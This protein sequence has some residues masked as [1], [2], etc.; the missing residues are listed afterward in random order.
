MGNTN[1]EKLTIGEITFGESKILPDVIKSLLKALVEKKVLSNDEA[2]KIVAESLNN[3]IDNIEAF[4]EKFESGTYVDD[5]QDARQVLLDNAGAFKDD[6]TL[7]E[8]LEFIYQER[9]RS[10]TE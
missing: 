8:L 5:F 1:S 2:D 6:E 9:G 4:G 10:M 7:D 3:Q